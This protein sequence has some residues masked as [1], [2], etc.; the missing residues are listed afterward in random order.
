MCDGLV[1]LKRRVDFRSWPEPRIAVKVKPGRE[2]LTAGELHLLYY[3][4]DKHMTDG[5]LFHC[6]LLAKLQRMIDEEEGR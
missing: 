4:F 6:D 2:T 5:N 1:Q 3:L